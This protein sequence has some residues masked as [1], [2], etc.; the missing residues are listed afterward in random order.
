VNDAGD[1]DGETGDGLETL[2]DK[3]LLR[4]SR[5]M[6]IPVCR[7]RDTRFGLLPADPLSFVSERLDD[8]GEPWGG[9]ETAAR[10]AGRT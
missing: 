4:S 1:L 7:P 8:S 10:H 5:S 6:P 9:V 2:A 3:S